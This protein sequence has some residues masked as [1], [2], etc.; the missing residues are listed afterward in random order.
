MA[1]NQSGV[2]KGKAQVDMINPM[3]FSLDGFIHGLD[4]VSLSPYSE[5]YLARPVTRGV[6]NY[7]INLVMTPASL[8]NNNRISID[9][10]EIGKRKKEKPVYRVPVGLALYVL[11]DRNDHIGFELPVTGN[12]SSPKFRLR[13][14]IW[15]TFEEFLLKTGTQPINFIGHKLGVDPESI[16]Q[17][18]FNYLQDSLG[19]DQIRTLD[20]IAQIITKKPELSFSL[21]QTT[22]PDEEK[23]LIAIKK[24]KQLYLSGAGKSEADQSF[25]GSLPLPDD[26]PGFL[27]FLGL[28]DEEADTKG[29][30]Y[31]T[32]CLQKAGNDQVSNE[33]NQLLERRQGLLKAYF[34]DKGL[35]ADSIQFR[36]ADL[37]NLPDD[38][39]KPQFV[40]EVSLE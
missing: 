39:K 9:N 11:K 38:L 24:A 23:M 2:L 5:F 26:D 27:A 1:L 17:I 33:F 22:D 3:N 25:V 29:E 18:P 4:M 10:L 37:R 6:F 20:R 15:K 7:D 13:R 40:V 36:T 30:H 28:T 16:K 31:R 21:V 35:P 34:A 8:E 12:P 32:S 19:T 14:I